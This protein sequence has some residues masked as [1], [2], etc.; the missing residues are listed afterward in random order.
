M[1]RYHITT[2]NMPVL[3]TAPL[4][5]C[6]YFKDEEHLTSL[7]SA[8][9]MN[10]F[11][12]NVNKNGL[13][14][15]SSL[16]LESLTINEL[17][18]YLKIVSLALR[19]LQNTI[20]YSNYDENNLESLF[21]EEELSQIRK[22][23]KIKVDEAYANFK[24]KIEYNKKTFDFKIYRNNVPKGLLEGIS[25]RRAKNDLADYY[26]S[27]A[28]RNLDIE[29]ASLLDKR[30]NGLVQSKLFR[31]YPHLLF[32]YS[33]IIDKNIER[34]KFALKNPDDIWKNY[35]KDV[36]SSYQCE[37]ENHPKAKQ[38][39]ANAKQ[40]VMA[41]STDRKAILANINREINIREQMEKFEGRPTIVNR[42]NGW[43]MPDEEEQVV[44]LDLK[45]SSNG[46]I[47]NLFV[48]TNKNKLYK[49]TG[50]AYDK[51]HVVDDK[52][53][54]AALSTRRTAIRADLTG[55][56]TFFE[57]KTEATRPYHLNKKYL[58]K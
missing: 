1:Q 31:N 34:Y 5:K 28:N 11:N 14:A 25:E 9:K 29:L 54:Q 58:C 40:G 55:N 21:T 49:V 50:I 38:A 48:F 7:D 37:L 56:F 33:K 36:E 51:L 4:G 18:L 42:L 43:E 41:V 2:D 8:I 30:L 15:L 6:Q 10:D 22:K 20:Q 3:C 35:D 47:D 13:M 45:F 39:K 24:N 12:N 26:L 32:D 44:S 57:T 27:D 46:E 23:N 17:K 19:N 52:G 53:F 16:S